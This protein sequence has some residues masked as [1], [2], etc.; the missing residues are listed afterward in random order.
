[1]DPSTHSPL[2][3]ESEPAFY[4]ETIRVA[5]LL[6]SDDARLGQFYADVLGLEERSRESGASLWSSPRAAGVP[7]GQ[8][9]AL[10]LVK[11]SGART[12]PPGTTGLFHL[13]FLLPDRPAL[14]AATRALLAWSERD[15]AVVFQGYSEHGVSEAVYGTDPDGN[16]VELTLDHPSATWPRR[17]DPND[18]LAIITRPLSVRGLLEQEAVPPQ[19]SAFSHA[20][21]NVASLAAAENLFVGK[22]GMQVTQRSYPGALFLAYGDYHHH[23]AVNIWEGAGAV[24]PPAGTVG[25]L[26]LEVQSPTGKRWHLSPI[27]L[28]RN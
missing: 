1:M 4:P 8:S 18:R 26:D 17:D 23:I 27:D 7:A 11:D 5:T 9:V 10:R 6:T 3:H 22:W 16:G 28:A 24:A 13:A 21:F 2:T 19:S 15:P 25:L 20:H 14:A 12:R